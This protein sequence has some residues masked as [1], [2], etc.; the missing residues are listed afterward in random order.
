VALV[1]GQKQQTCATAAA[2][3]KET[4]AAQ[5]QVTVPARRQMKT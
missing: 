2:N 1:I 5:V 3:I 4:A